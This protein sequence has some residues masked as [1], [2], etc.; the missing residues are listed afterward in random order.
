LYITIIA[1]L[2][3]QLKE[4]KIWLA[5]ILVLNCIGLLFCGNYLIRAILF[6]YSNFFIRR[7]LD[8]VINQRFSTE[9]G[10]LL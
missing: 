3:T 2:G 8:S 6:P 4:Q 5:C 10:R 1:A 9:F 7:Q